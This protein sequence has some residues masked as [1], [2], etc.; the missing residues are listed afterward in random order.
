MTQAENQAN[1]TQAYSIACVSIILGICAQIALKY[2]ATGFGNIDFEGVGFSLSAYLSDT[3]ALTALGQLILGG[4][5]YGVSMIVWIVTLKHLPLSSAYP[6]LALSYPIVS[7]VAVYF[8]GLGEEL[9]GSQWLGIV[10][11][12]CGVYLAAKPDKEST[13]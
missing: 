4:A 7:L 9:S 13:N 8:T 12:S 11:I 5:L 3:H 1:Y 6:L 2:S 10:L